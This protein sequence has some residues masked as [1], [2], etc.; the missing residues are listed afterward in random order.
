MV[1]KYLQNV[2]IC[3]LFFYSSTINAK[4]KTINQ[5][6]QIKK[7]EI[8][9]KD[10]VIDENRLPLKLEDLIY[11]ALERNINTR[12]A[13][14]DVKIAEKELK[15][16]KSVYYP[17]I[18]ISG[19]YQE[20]DGDAYTTKQQNK[21]G[22][23]SA[24]YEV[25][26]FGKSVYK[27]KALRHYLNSAKYKKDQITQEVI[28]N[29]IENYYGLLSLQAQKEAAIETEKA[30]QE[31]F[32]A[33]SLKYKIGIVPLVDKLKSENSYSRNKLSRL[34][35]ENSIK[36]QKANL[37]LLLNLDPNY[38]LYIETPDVNVKKVNKKVE[39]YIKDAKNNRIDLKYL[40]EQ[41]NGKLDSLTSLKLS[42]LPTINA[43]GY[44]GVSKNFTKYYKQPSYES[45][46]IKLSVS[47]PLFTGF[48]TTNTIK[49]KEEEIKSINLKIE[50]L[51]KSI[52]TEVWNAYYDFN[53]TQN[54]YFIAKDLLKTAQE[55][56][57]VQLGMYKNSKSSML[58][59][60]NAQEQLENARYEFI[61]S[62]Y[63]LL[64]YRIKLLK[65]IGK[66]NLE[67]I[68]NIDNL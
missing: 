23:I 7:T 57:K 54:S 13:I 39:D 9:T 15:A 37:N 17:N 11:L 25:F 2:I 41:K 46:E 44:F 38:V 27:I 68:I 29:V 61:N 52:S 24:S 65:T 47:V 40:K 6:E 20:T 21:G 66:M 33:A 49:S 32:K 60:L 51:E 45:S 30:S 4:D 8:K 64:I 53:T 31:A 63:N 28:Y 18:S 5:Q 22:G 34:K 55:S 43:S 62:K 58:D 67:N 42:R 50:E 14:I 56:A 16:N 48:Y 10:L 19:T 12:S 1:L 35:I 59:V 3:F 36:K 26:A